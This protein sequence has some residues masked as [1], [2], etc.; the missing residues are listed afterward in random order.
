MK[1]TSFGVQAKLTLAFL[2]ATVIP[3][4]VVISVSSFHANRIQRKAQEIQGCDV[5]LE[6]MTQQYEEA[7]LAMKDAAITWVQQHLPSEQQPLGAEFKQTITMLSDEKLA[8]L[9]KMKAEMLQTYQ[10]Q[11][12]EFL[13]GYEQ[14]QMFL[15]GVLIGVSIISVAIS[16]FIGRMLTQP[17]VQLTEAAQKISHGD[18]RQTISVRSH[19]E[20]GQLSAAFAAMIN[21][22]QSIT[23]SAHNIAQGNIQEVFPPKSTDDLLGTAFHSMGQYLHSIVGAAHQIASGNFVQTLAVKSAHDVLGQA[24]HKMTMNLVETIRRIKHEV[25]LVEQTSATTAARS[26]QDMKMVEDVLSSAE[27]TSASMM[28]MQASVEEVSENMKALSGAIE[29]TV[30]SIEQMNM[31]IKQIASNSTGLSDSAEATFK[32]IQ[33]IGDSIAHLVEASHEAETSSHEASESAHAGQTSVR[34]IIEGMT[35][36]HAVVSKSAEM[37]KALGTRS[38]E[39][40]SITSLIDD[41]AGQTQLLALNASIIAAQAGEHGRGFAVV[42]QE[43]K[44]LANRSSSAAKDIED[45]IKGV[46]SE[47]Q[48]AAESMAKGRQAVEEGVALANRGGEALDKILRSVEKTLSSIHAST[49]IATEQSRLSEQVRQYMENVVAIVNEIVR[50]TGEQ[51]QGAAQITDAVSNMRDLS[52]QVKRATTEQTQGTHHVLEAMDNV[53]GRV[54]ESSTRAQGLAKVAADLARQ[55][56]T[57]KGLLDQFQ[58]DAPASA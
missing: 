40:G 36:I 53:T 5:H 55:T 22:M 48:Q 6:K 3:L 25:Q 21:Y 47:S 24:F 42:A 43:V 13:S 51:Q 57:L 28:Q 52:E 19:D 23:Q 1:P 12:D 49:K 7:H 26:E 50:A 18:L 54:Q 44:E 41:I 58:I 16:F 29:E 14:R 34:E 45:L 11:F 9:R 20:I 46:Q 56:H 8:V 32:V 15:L 27:E 38:E 30:T 4:L 2:A 39:I 17:L 10:Q 33:D 37:I 35:M 31:A